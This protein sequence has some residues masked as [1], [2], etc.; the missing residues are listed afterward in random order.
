MH[1]RAE[2]SRGVLS[3]T[4]EIA[5]NLAREQRDAGVPQAERLANLEKSLRA[6]WPK[7]RTE[8]WHYSCEHCHDTGWSCEDCPRRPCGRSRPHSPHPFV[9]T[10]SCAKGAAIRANLD[11]RQKPVEVE[12]AG[13][14]KPMVRIGR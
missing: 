13:T 1:R 7:S 12:K 2:P 6:A 4:M 3:Q 10:C 8:P 5:L 14:S 11:K 9:Y